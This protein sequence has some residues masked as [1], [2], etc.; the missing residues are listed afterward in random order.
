MKTQTD[1]PQTDSSQLGTTKRPAGNKW[2]HSAN[3][4]QLA[5][6]NDSKLVQEVYE[7]ILWRIDAKRQANETLAVGLTGCLRKSGATSIVANL[8]VRASDQQR[9]RVLLIDANWPDGDGNSARGHSPGLSKTFDLPR[10]AGLYD[11]LSG[12]ISPRECEPQTVTENL[13]ILSRGKWGEAQPTHVRPELV[14][15]M[16]SDLKSEYSLILVDLPAAEE[17]RNAL[18]LARQ[19]D[20]TLLISRFEAVKQPQAQRALRRLQEDGVA[21]WGSILNRHRE[22][23]PKWLRNWL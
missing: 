10:E 23:V 22:Y 5:K 1:S 14:E 21:V 13:D 12:D 20:G 7:S 16:L 18:P 6:R 9:G 15:E 11:I 2:R 4:P 17:L 3:L 8:A 19:L